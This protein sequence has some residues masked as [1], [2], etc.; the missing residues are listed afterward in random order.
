MRGIV[1]NLCTSGRNF[2]TSF[3]R[4][5]ELENFTYVCPGQPSQIVAQRDST[6]SDFRLMD[7]KAC[8][9]ILSRRLATFTA[10]LPKGQMKGTASLTFYFP[11]YLSHPRC[12]LL[13]YLLSISAPGS[14]TTLDS[15]L[16]YHFSPCTLSRSYKLSD[17]TFCISSTLYIKWLP[18]YLPW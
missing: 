17:I 10:I 11:L 9:F 16:I 1:S 5:A 12:A 14:S 13:P 3:V 18:V 2:P 15:V 6:A 4:T 7:R 8:T